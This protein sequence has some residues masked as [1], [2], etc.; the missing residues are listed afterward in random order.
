MQGGKSYAEIPSEELAYPFI[1]SCI[2]FDVSKSLPENRVLLLKGAPLRFVQG[3]SR[4]LKET[5]SIS[6]TVVQV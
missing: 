1:F 2:G 6:N 3:P 5:Y 4:N